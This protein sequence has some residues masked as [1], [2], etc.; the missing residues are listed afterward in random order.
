MTLFVCHEHQIK[1]ALMIS[2]EKVGKKR[3]CFSFLS[4][5]KACIEYKLM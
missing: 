2:Y 5:K 4:Q 1:K 3:A